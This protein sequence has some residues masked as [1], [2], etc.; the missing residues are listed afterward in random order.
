M[1]MKQWLY[2]TG[3]HVRS[4]FYGYLADKTF[5]KDYSRLIQLLS[6]TYK[7]NSS[8]QC[9]YDY[10][11]NVMDMIN[12]YIARKSQHYRLLIEGAS[13]N[14]YDYNQNNYF[15]ITCGGTRKLYLNK[16]VFYNR[17]QPRGIF[18]NRWKMVVASFCYQ[19][20]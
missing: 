9:C 16:E 4:Q 19:L 2:P 20:P 11:S 10:I 7:A 18:C 1:S 13:R 8:Q 6:K 5:L 15:S 17:A 12:N 14:C 3:C